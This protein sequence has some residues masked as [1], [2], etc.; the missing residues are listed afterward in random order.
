[1]INKAQIIKQLQRPTLLRKVD[2]KVGGGLPRA[3]SDHFGTTTLTSSPIGSSTMGTPTDPLS[4]NASPSDPAKSNLASLDPVHA[5]PGFRTVSPPLD[6][7]VSPRSRREGPVPQHSEDA[8]DVLNGKDLK[9]V[10][11]MHIGG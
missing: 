5:N 11:V 8:A 3:R 10:S 1:M 9:N 7:Q 2:R 6:P 4:G